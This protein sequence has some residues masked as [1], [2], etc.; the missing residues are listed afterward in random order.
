MKKY[1]NVAL[2]YAIAA[3]VGRRFLPGLAVLLHWQAS[4]FGL[5]F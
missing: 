2:V 4:C 1:L 3:M 5:C